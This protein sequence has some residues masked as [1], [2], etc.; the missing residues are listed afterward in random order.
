MTLKMT[1]PVAVAATKAGFSRTTGYRLKASS[2]LRSQKKAPRSRRRSDP[3][4][5]AQRDFRGRSAATSKVSTGVAAGR[6]F[7]GT[8]A[9]PCGSELRHSSHARATH[10]RAEHGPEQEAMFRQVNEP[11]KMGLSDV[12]DMGKPGVTIANEPLVHRLHHFRFGAVTVV[13]R[14]GAHVKR[15]F[16]RRPRGF[17]SPMLN[18]DDAGC[19]SR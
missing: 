3:R 18:A 6:Y 1:D 16:V 9:P 14:S 15:P 17:S 13:F 7:R 11:G 12:T 4:R 19:R 8:A 10:P 5:P 2:R